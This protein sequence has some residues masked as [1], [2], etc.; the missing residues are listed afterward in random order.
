MTDTALRAARRTNIAERAQADI[1]RGH[2]VQKKTSGSGSGTALHK[3]RMSMKIRSMT[4][5]IQTDMKK[6]L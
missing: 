2:S 3:I 4:L 6:S 1:S 5:H